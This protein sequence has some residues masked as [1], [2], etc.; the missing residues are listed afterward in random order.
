MP[1]HTDKLI[2]LDAR[3]PRKRLP[4]LPATLV[5]KPC[6]DVANH[7][8]DLGFLAVTRE[9]AVSRASRPKRFRLEFDD[10]SGV[11]VRGCGLIGRDPAPVAGSDVEHL[12]ALKDNS[13]SLSRTHLEFG[14]EESGLWVRDCFS[15]NG[16]GIEFGG[17]QARLVPGQPVHAPAWSTIHFG[18]RRAKVQDITGR[19]RV[20]NAT[21][22]WGIATRIGVTHVQNEDAFC[23]AAPVFVVADGLGAHHR[24][25]VASSEAI[26]ALLTL[27]GR[28][29][30]TER[31][32]QQCLSD[33]R[34]RISRIPVGAA[35]PPAT[36]LSGVII[37][38]AETAPMWMVVNIG[39]SR[40]YRLDAEMFRQISVDHSIGQDLVDR[41]AVAS[42]SASCLPFG[43]MLT[44]ALTADSE[45]TADVWL[46]PME[47]DDRILVCSDG[48]TKALADDT[49]AAVLREIPDPLEAAEELADAALSTGERDDVTVLI[50]DAVAIDESRRRSEL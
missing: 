8:K 24:G 39:D 12:V 46:L 25:D 9:L 47:A 18:E 23:T 5:S 26:E 13:L 32:L 6:V 19:A 21:V 2:A 16:S 49:I 41:G 33:A 43:N 35:R 37:T 27:T 7:A 42:S 34:S 10:G 38:R 44:R 28:T 3:R 31:M 50:V 1:D 45:P 4:R 29:D 11:V 30:V 15:T 20:G 36:T 14:L 48:L 40:T 17:Q 22:D